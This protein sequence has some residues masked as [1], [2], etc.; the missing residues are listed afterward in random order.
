MYMSASTIAHDPL[1]HLCS[2]YM[3]GAIGAHVKFHAT[4]SS[5]QL[6]V[7]INLIKTVLVLI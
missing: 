5:G 4:V 6:Q 1:F 3:H 2:N 7:S